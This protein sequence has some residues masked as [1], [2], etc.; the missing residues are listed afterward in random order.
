MNWVKGEIAGKIL[1]QVD[2]CEVSYIDADELWTYVGKK[3][4][5]LAVMGC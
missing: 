3:I 2:V 4:M 1:A 5:L